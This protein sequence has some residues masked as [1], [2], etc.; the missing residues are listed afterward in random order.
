MAELGLVEF[1]RNL[2]LQQ[3]TLPPV[4]LYLLVDIQSPYVFYIQVYLSMEA[5]TDTVL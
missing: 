5:L 4:P 2:N 1:L 3:F